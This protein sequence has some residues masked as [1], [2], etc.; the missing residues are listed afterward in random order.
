MWTDGPLTWTDGPDG[1]NL[2]FPE[3]M[4]TAAVRRGVDRAREH[5]HEIV[6]AWLSRDAD[7]KPLADAG[8]ERGWSPW[9]MTA[10]L[11]DWRPAADPRIELE[12]QPAHGD[13]D[14]RSAWY[15]AAYTPDARRFAGR[16]WA[17]LDADLAGIFDMEALARDDAAHS[18]AGSGPTTMS[19]R[20][21]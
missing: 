17:F 6:G 14:A 1:Q 3:T 11:S 16:A 4:S 9:W 7:P 12:Q 5:G 20:R 15:A 13:D 18:E 2:M 10:D 21:P 8:F 19:T